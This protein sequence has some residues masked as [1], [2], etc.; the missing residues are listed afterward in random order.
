MS[1]SSSATTTTVMAASTGKSMSLSNKITSAIAQA[2]GHSLPTII[3]EIRENTVPASSAPPA[4]P[5]VPLLL[6][7]LWAPW[8]LFQVLC[9]SQH[10]YLHSRPCKPP[11]TP[12]QFVPHSHLCHPLWP[13]MLAAR[14][15]IWVVCCSHLLWTWHLWLVQDACEFPLNWFQ[16]LRVVSLWNWPTYCQ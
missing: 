8:R 15:P 6:W 1:P 9:G 5:P 3:A 14:Q 11:L 12:T 4:P 13:L 16:R 10:L 2:F 7:L